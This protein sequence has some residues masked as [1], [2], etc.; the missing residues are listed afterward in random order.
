MTQKHR[1]SAVVEESSAGFGDA[2][3]AA[4]PDAIIV[5]GSDGTIVEFNP[6]AEHIF[7]RARADVVGT[8]L[9]DALTLATHRNSHRTDLSRLW[10]A[11]SARFIGRT[12]PAIAMRGDGRPF[13][14][15]VSANVVPT[16][17]NLV[18]LFVR[19]R[20]T[21]GPN[22]SI[23]EPDSPADDDAAVWGSREML[24]IIMRS[25][26][27]I[28]FA[29]DLSGVIQVSTGSGL[30]ALGFQPGQLVGTNV[31]EIYKD[32]PEVAEYHRRALRGEE[33]RAQ[34]DIGDR[35]LETLYRPIFSASGRLVGT[36]GV[37]DD[38]TV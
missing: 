29:V 28:V 1:H 26:P 38:I 10:S 11:D 5:A 34:V 19:D 13:A 31:F 12:F 8:D 30:A 33:F 21:N 23:P 36:V 25:A 6:M 18:V 16:E 9:F 35:S 2:I 3:V 7:G 17:R 27:G 37:S 20:S 15:E 24:A 32:M 22:P 4:A 14:V